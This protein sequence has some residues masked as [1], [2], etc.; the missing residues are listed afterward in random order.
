MMKRI[1]GGCFFS[2][3][4]QA[5]NA[6]AHRT[7]MKKIGFMLFIIFGSRDPFLSGDQQDQ[8]EANADVGNR[9][10]DFEGVCI[11]AMKRTLFTGK[12]NVEMHCKYDQGVINDQ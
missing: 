4:W 12:S 10:M 9:Q 6:K 1:L 2:F 3:G 11:I 8:T 7:M 5:L